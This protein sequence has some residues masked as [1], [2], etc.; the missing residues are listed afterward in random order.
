MTATDTDDQPGI[1]EGRQHR[2]GDAGVV[3][4]E[5]RQEGQDVDLFLAAASRVS[6][7]YLIHWSSA[8]ATRPPG[9]R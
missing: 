1:A 7:R 9:R 2:E 8:T 4:A 6:T 5:E 3:G